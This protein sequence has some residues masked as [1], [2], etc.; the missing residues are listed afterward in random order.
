MTD[1]M[2]NFITITKIIIFMCNNQKKETK[3][4]NLAKICQEFNIQV[5]PYNILFIL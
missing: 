2:S 3:Y 4:L 5:K 1:I